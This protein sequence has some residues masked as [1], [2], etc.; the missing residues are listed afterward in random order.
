[1]VDN[2]PV[3]NFCNCRPDKSQ[4]AR[5]F[6]IGSLLNV[7]RALFVTDFETLKVCTCD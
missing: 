4:T 6:E 1:M 2:I 7:N 3:K 5:Y